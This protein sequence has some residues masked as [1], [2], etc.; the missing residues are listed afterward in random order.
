MK[1][2]LGLGPAGS[3][4]SETSQLYSARRQIR[5]NITANTAM[6]LVMFAFAESIQLRPTRGHVFLEL[7]CEES[8]SLLLLGESGSGKTQAVAW[9][10][11][12]LKEAPSRGSRVES[13]KHSEPA[14]DLPGVL[15]RRR[16]EGL[17]GA[18]DAFSACAP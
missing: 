5:A 1:R 17:W 15:Q 2:V 9:C 13:F 16:A 14:D 10:L 4:S 6:V 8:K 7:P 3:A 18:W 11:Q 12:R